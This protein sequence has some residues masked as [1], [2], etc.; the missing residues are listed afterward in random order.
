MRGWAVVREAV[1]RCQR[2]VGEAEG[3]G[4]RGGR[5]VGCQS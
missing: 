3:E 2:R 4:G 5:G 1:E